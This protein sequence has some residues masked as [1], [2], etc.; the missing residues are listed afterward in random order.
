MEKLNIINT[1]NGMATEALMLQ[2]DRVMLQA[3]GSGQMVVEGSLYG[4]VW[5]LVQPILP[6]CQSMSR[7]IVVE[8]LSGAYVR[9]REI[10][11]HLT[12]AS[13]AYDIPSTAEDAREK[14]ELQRQTNEN[15]REAQEGQRREAEIVREGHEETRK[16]N[17]LNR[18]KAEGIREANESQRIRQE[19][20]RELAESN[21]IA[22]EIKRHDAEVVRGQ[23]ETN[24]EKAESQR[25]LM[26]SNRAKAEV[27]RGQEEADRVK[28][29][30]SREKAEATRQSQESTR[31]AQEG[32]RREAEIVREGHEETRE[33]QEGQRVGAE[34]AR[35]EKYSALEAEVEALLQRVYDGGYAIDVLRALIDNAGHHKA[36]SYDSEGDYK[37]CGYPTV[38]VGHGTP[39]ADTLPEQRGIPQ[40]IGQQY[41]D[42][43]ADGGG[44]Y[45]ATGTTSVSHW[46][47]A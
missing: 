30:T 20:D 39:S 36:L 28:A 37:V 43:D 10:D 44:L 18:G 31:E 41:I 40:F 1:P 2:H 11:G 42:L 29:E 47:K 3:D 45:Y 5:S 24:R 46:K 14:N 8:L 25:G 27:S 13:Y 16:E 17:E 21:R 15:T 22:D 12:G 38:A 4:D 6:S 9:I 26:E 7:T 19:G 32:Q 35:D 33:A 23:S 34:A